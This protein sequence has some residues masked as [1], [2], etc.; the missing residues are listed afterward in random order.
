MGPFVHRLMRPAVQYILFFCV[1][2]LHYC[3]ELL[4]KHISERHLVS[5]CMIGFF[6]AMNMGS[7]VCS[8]S[9]YTFCCYEYLLEHQMCINQTMKIVPN[10]C[11]VYFC[12]G[13]IC[14][15]RKKHNGQMFEEIVKCFKKFKLRFTSSVG[16]NAAGAEC[17]SPERGTK[18][19]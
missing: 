15:K 17:L 14:L 19:L 2:N 1:I 6:I 9:K 12:L 11:A 16:R 4:R 10:K 3:T 7:V 5:P 8:E 18:S 13:N